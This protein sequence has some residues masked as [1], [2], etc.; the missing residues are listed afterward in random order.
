MNL[1]RW[2]ALMIIPMKNNL[3]SYQGQGYPR[4]HDILQAIFIV[5]GLPKQPYFVFIK[6]KSCITSYWINDGNKMSTL[7]GKRD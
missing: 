4:L 1:K 3:P 2:A 6:S 5:L 7:F